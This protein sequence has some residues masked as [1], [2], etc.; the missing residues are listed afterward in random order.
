MWNR[1][2]CGRSTAAA[3]GLNDVSFFQI[4]A[5]I[6]EHVIESST[7]CHLRSNVTLYPQLETIRAFW[8][9]QKEK[10]RVWNMGTVILHCA[11]VLKISNRPSLDAQGKKDVHSVYFQ[12]NYIKKTFH[13]LLTYKET[14]FHRTS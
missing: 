14:Y 12:Q 3:L 13:R 5:K 4:H 10:H 7:T 11:L 6:A 1:K 9:A 2:A 8:I